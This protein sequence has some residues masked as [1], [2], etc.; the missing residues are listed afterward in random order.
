MLPTI[1]KGDLIIYK[2]F[3]HQTDILQ[4]GLVV[5]AKHPLKDNSLIIKRISKINYSNVEVLGDNLSTSIDSR[6]F[7]Q[8]NKR[9][10]KGIVER[11]IPKENSFSIFK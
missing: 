1:N 8:I 6:Q 10:I 11:I 7:G 3:K 9:Q 4:E 5:V 2:P